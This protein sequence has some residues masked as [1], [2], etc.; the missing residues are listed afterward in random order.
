[1]KMSRRILDDYKTNDKNFESTHAVIMTS[2]AKQRNVTIQLLFQNY[3]LDSD[4]NLYTS[5]RH[6]YKTYG[7]KFKSTHVVIISSHAKERNITIQD[8][9]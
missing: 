2:N 9:L 5:F 1:M 8:L 6:V 7:K 4:E 3:W